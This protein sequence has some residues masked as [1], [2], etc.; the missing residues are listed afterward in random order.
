MKA[1]EKDRSR[2]YDSAN[3]FAADVQRY[4]AGEPVQAVPPSAGYRLRKFAKRNRAAVLTAGVVAVVL[5]AATGVS[6]TFGLLASRAEGVAEQRRL[7]AVANE[8]R[9]VQAGEQLRD[10]RDEL[11]ASLY[12]ARCPLIQGAWDAGEYDRLHRLLAFQLPAAGQRDHRG[13]EWHYLDRQINADLRTAAISPKDAYDDLMVSL[14]RASLLRMSPDGTRLLRVTRSDNNWDLYKCELWLRSFDTTTGREQFAIRYP[15]P[16]SHGASYSPDGKWIVAAAPKEI[17]DDTGELYRWDAATGAE[18]RRARGIISDRTPLAGPDALPAVWGGRLWDGKAVR[19]IGTGSAVLAVSHDGT[20]L[21]VEKDG[22]VELID[23]RTGQPLSKAD[24]PR[25]L[26]G[27]S[28]K[29]HMAA[30]TERVVFSPTAATRRRGRQAIGLGGRAAEAGGGR[31]AGEPPS[32]Q[33]D[34]TR[35]A[36]IRQRDAVFVEADFGQVR[37]IVPSPTR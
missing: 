33:P 10:A 2:R 22:A 30:R 34:G 32:V 31:G 27:S 17:L 7:D 23:T 26:L 14:T 21:A 37:R 4:L 11:W 28:P 29:E 6:L 16:F 5:L 15:A 19:P 12:A 1:L 18:D 35:I 25:I 13:F 8:A 9:A 3:S 24:D 36:Y 20:L